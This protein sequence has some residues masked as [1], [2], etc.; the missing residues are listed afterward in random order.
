MKPLNLLL[1]FLLVFSIACSNDD[2]ESS[3]PLEPPVVLPD[4]IAYLALGD[5]YTIGQG[6]EEDQR[7]PVQLSERLE[8]SGY[9]IRET[10][11]I[12]FTG[13]TTRNLLSALENNDTDNFNLVSL[14]IGVNNQFQGRPFNVFQEEFNQLLEQSIQYAGGAERVFVVSIPDYGVTPFGASNAETIAQQLDEY[15]AYMEEQAESKDIP[16]IDITE[17]SRQLGDGPG[18]LAEDNL[19]PSGEQYAQWVEEILPVVKESIGRI[20]RACSIHKRRLQTD[21]INSFS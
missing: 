18:A 14:L 21:F 20:N 17:I 1:F 16:F 2:D 11:I 13:W 19:H 6:V 5:S 3:T 15:N 4:T 8:E 7:W 10:K 12:A 9:I